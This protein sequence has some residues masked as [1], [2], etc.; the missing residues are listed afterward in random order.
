MK[1]IDQLRRDAKALK[2]AYAA[3]DAVAR[4]RVA[5]VSPRPAETPLKHA[6]FLHVIARENSFASWPSLKLAVDL[7]GMDV[8]TKRQRLKLALHQGYF[9][10]VEH[11][12]AD[13]PTLAEGALGLQIALYQRAAVE[14]ALRNDPNRAVEL[15]G[16]APPMIH[17]AY[18][19]IIKHWP[20]RTAD[21]LAIAE[22]LL[23]HGA[24]VNQGA[25]AY[26]G[27]D[28]MLSPLYFAIG[29]ADNMVLARWLLAHGANPDDNE[30]LYHST[31]LGHHEG[32]RMLL[33]HGAE[34]NGTNALLR[35]MDFD[36]LDAV[37]MLLEAGALADAFDGSPVGGEQPS[38]IPALH[39]A[40]RRMCSAE[41]IDM[42]LKA[43]ADP[44]SRF[45]G[46]SAYAY[47]RVFGNRALAEAIEARGGSVA[48]TADEVL[49]AKAADGLETVGL[50]IVPEA[51]PLPY[52]DIIRTILHLPG[53]LD[54]VRR[55]VALG[56]DPDRA[57]GEGLT[58]VQVAGWEGLPD[59][60]AYLLE[61][62]PDLG[63]INNYGGTLLGTILH[64]SEN[65][66]ARAERDHIACLELALSAGT[67]LPRR[68][69][70]Q[71]GDEDIANFLAD[72]AEAHPDQVLEA[73]AL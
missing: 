48:L 25:P 72:W 7:L 3:G 13:T 15:I 10:L 62:N 35:A 57:D 34:P 33:A 26:E 18:S 40:A 4:Q 19:R 50:R 61:L 8:A 14:E 20:E 21:M 5:S 39:Q 59:V 53:K 22:L 1:S 2:R 43:G 65:C 45:E 27:S 12:L 9:K 23:A 55:L 38:V 56:L 41:M 67:G 63:H 51:L 64:G 42:L 70:E 58:P 36:D 32:L 28:H 29:H 16:M 60:M 49:L 54:H 52:Q 24:D 17:L 31:E 69:L 71:A 68:A 44:D 73:G 47:A 66:P 46:C 6:D 30:S 11:L 37:Q